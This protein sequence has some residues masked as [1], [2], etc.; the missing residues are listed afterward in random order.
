M[1]RKNEGDNINSRRKKRCTKVIDLNDIMS[2]ID[3]NKRYKEKYIINIPLKERN[4]NNNNNKQ[5]NVAKFKEEY[6]KMSIKKFNKLYPR[7]IYN[8]GINKK[9]HKC[10]RKCNFW[11][12]D[13]KCYDKWKIFICIDSLNIHECGYSCQTYHEVDGYYV[14]YMTGKMLDRIVT[15]NFKEMKYWEKDKIHFT[16]NNNDNDIR[17]NN[18]EKQS[19]MDNKIVDNIRAPVSKEQ[20]DDDDDE[21]RG[22]ISRRRKRNNKKYN[23]NDN[24][25]IYRDETLTVETCDIKD[26]R[27]YIDYAFNVVNSIILGTK[28]ESMSIYVRERKH[29]TAI[30]SVKTSILSYKNKKKRIYGLDLIDIYAKTVSSFNNMDFDKDGNLTQQGREN[31]LNKQE[32][33]TKENKIKEISTEIA[34]HWI[35]FSK[36]Y[37]TLINKPVTYKQKDKW[38]ILKSVSYDMFI[39]I[40][41][42]A[43][44]RGKEIQGV[45]SITKYSILNELPPINKLQS[46]INNDG[47][48]VPLQ[49]TTKRIPPIDGTRSEL[50]KKNEITKIKQMIIGNKVYKKKTPRRK[51]KL[52]KMA[53][54]I[55]NLLTKNIIETQAV[56]QFD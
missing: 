9:T 13:L 15:N 2:D 56:L 55:V 14:C 17:Q 6:I 23:E 4:N 7:T 37:K 36:I 27:Y 1:K 45:N 28:M 51:K 43:M 40:M 42:Y 52:T 53:R 47:C 32:K 3:K 48:F 8:D 38:Q 5:E 19:N 16:L 11:E 25:D 49:R 26:I 21:L 54:M 50:F 33:Y 24:K 44:Q 39:S 35:H 12:S 20:K 29:R 22:N 30:T 18:L 46:V 34:Q 31:R 10:D 41:L